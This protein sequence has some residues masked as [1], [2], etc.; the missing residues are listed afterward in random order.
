MKEL[1]NDNNLI[2]TLRTENRMQKELLSIKDKQLA[3]VHNTNIEAL[4]KLDAFEK[5]LYLMLK[6]KYEK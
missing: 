6:E 3:K 4:D 2:E 5:C 1:K